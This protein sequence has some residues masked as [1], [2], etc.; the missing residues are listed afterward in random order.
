MRDL[1]LGSDS[2]VG[3]PFVGGCYVGGPFFR[4]VM[5]MAQLSGVVLS[6][7]L[8]LG[9]VISVTHSSGAL[10]RCPFCQGPLCRWPLLLGPLCWSR[11]FVKGRY[12]EGALL[13]GAVMSVALLSGAVIFLWPSLCRGCFMRPFWQELDVIG[14]L[15]VGGFFSLGPL[16]RWL[17]LGAVMYVALFVGAVLQGRFDRSYLS[18]PLC[19]WPI[20][21]LKVGPLCLWSFCRFFLCRWL[22]WHEP[23]YW[24]FL[25][26]GHF[27]FVGW[28][29]SPSGWIIIITTTIVIHIW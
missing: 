11:P 21:S 17:L 13:S 4:A 10:C 19:R 6:M 28:Y 27:T 29:G 1:L 15:H 2:Y 12:F 26:G 14:S 8:L 16:Y 24:W 18:R 3:G 9:A 25:I 22:F 7:A 23:L 20:L 5:S